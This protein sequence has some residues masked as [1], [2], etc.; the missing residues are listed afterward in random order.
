MYRAD[1]VGRYMLDLNPERQSVRSHRT[2]D[3][4]I[5]FVAEDLKERDS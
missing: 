2:V 3:C 5:P 1:L 4:N